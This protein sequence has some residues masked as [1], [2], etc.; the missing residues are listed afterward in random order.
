MY[1]QR[2]GALL[3]RSILALVGFILI[4][5]TEG[6]GADWRLYS[7]DRGGLHYYDTESITRS[8]TKTVIVSEKTVYTAERASE[9][10]TKFGSD[11]KELSYC[12]ISN[13]FNCED[14]KVRHLLQ[15]YYS[16]EGKPLPVFRDR[17]WRNIVPGSVAGAL[18]KI[19]CTQK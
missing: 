14:K 5:H 1:S 12:M 15:S 7:E 19:I 2:H 17:P 8:L 6:W 13:E 9:I 11:F 4:F 3:A 18:Y 10:V 16:K